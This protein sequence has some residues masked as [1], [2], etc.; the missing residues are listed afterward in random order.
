MKIWDNISKFILRLF[1]KKFLIDY[2]QV[3]QNE[4]QMLKI[5]SNIIFLKFYEGHDPL[6]SL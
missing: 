6:I 5:I 1:T 4:V 3:S 2:F